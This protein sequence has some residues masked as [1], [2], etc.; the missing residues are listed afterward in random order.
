MTT[1]TVVC[2]D[3]ITVANG[4]SWWKQLQ[5]NQPKSIRQAFEEQ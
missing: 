5:V 3:E 2:S 4:L 1:V